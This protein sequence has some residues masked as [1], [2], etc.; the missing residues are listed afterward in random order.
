MRLK[1]FSSVVLPEPV[2]PETRM[3]RR[4]RAAISSRRATAGI[5]LPFATMAAKSSFF[6]VNLRMEMQAPSSASGGKITLT[7]LPSGRRASQSGLEF[8]DAPAD[9]RH[10]LLR[11]HGGMLRI[12]EAHVDFCS[13]PRTSMNTVS[14]PFTMMSLIESSR[15]SGSSGPKPTMSSV[16]SWAS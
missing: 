3:F 2:P 12:A 6:L 9:R 10:H 5:M 13:L 1:A 11:H 8:V 14:G 7:R 4:Q 15:S 16:S